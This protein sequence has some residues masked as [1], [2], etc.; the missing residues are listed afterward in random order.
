[1][2]LVISVATPGYGLHVS[3]R[4]VSKADAPYDAYA[5]KTVVF[6][7]TDGLVVL[8]YTGAAFLDGI[9]TDTWIADVVSGGLCAD[10]GGAIMYG[11]FP[12]RDTGSTLAELSRRL[13]VGRIFEVL[14][15]AVCATGWQWNAR[16]ARA[17]CRPVLWIL[18]RGSGAL[19]WHQQMP[20]HLLERRAEFRMKPIGNWPLGDKA[21]RD[22]KSKV[23]EAGPD[24]DLVEEMI[25][26]SIGAASEKRPGSI[27]R[28]CM[29]VVVKP[30]AG[31]PNA[32][33]R[34]IPAA[35]H[36]GQA[37]GQDVEV[38][39]TPWMVAPDAIHAPALTVGGL[40]CEQGLLTYAIEAPEVPGDQALKGAF[41]TQERPP[42]R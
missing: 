12:L 19:Q 23:G 21:W 37:F 5:N 39:F 36:L 20:R 18:D 29:S 8:G 2:T 11:A 3:D 6:R 28:H 16:R 14:H 34:F 24:V 13:R 4:L 33:V 15:G 41:Q 10:A 40:N 7:A 1:V 30:G 32:R 22:L 25:V 27:G 9:P 17:H 31:Y 35:A 26:N 38:A 42:P